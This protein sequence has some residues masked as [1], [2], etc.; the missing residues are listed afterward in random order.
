MYTRVSIQSI[1]SIT[2]TNNHGSIWSVSYKEKVTVVQ[3]TYISY[4][5]NL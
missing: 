2:D 4:I 5:T 1:Q 3:E